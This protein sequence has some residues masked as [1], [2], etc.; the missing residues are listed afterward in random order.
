MIKHMIS[1]AISVIMLFSAAA[2]SASA[3]NHGTVMPVNTGSAQGFDQTSILV[4]FSAGSSPADRAAQ[5]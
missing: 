4:R 3:E 1:A 5:R 2:I